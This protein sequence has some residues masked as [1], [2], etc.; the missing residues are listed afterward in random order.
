MLNI[1][2]FEPEI[3]PNTGNIMRLAANTGCNLHLIEPLGFAIDTKSLRRAGL[4]Y[5][6]LIE[7]KTYKNYQAFI[8]ANPKARIFAATTKGSQAHCQVQYR[9][10]D[11]LIFGPESRG[12]PEAILTDSSITDRIRIPM[13]ANSRSLNLANSVAVI[14][15]EALRQLNYPEL[16]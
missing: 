15:Y 16:S 5:Q 4:D 7:L 2:L 11:Y 10:E 9:L 14:C 8:Q 3:P 12:L 1:V 13:Q 6:D